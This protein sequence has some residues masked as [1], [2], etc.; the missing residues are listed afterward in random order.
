VNPHTQH[1]PMTNPGQYSYLLDALPQNIDTLHRIVNNIFIHMWKMARVRVPN[2]RKSDYAIR[3]VETILK[4]VMTYDA[5]EIT[6]QRPRSKQFIGDCRHS[7][8]LLCAM[9]RQQ[10]IPARVRHGYCQYISDDGIKFQYHVITEYHDGTRWILEDPDIIRH[11]IPYTDFLFGAQAWELYRAGKINPEQFHLHHDAIGA[12][13]FPIPMLRDIA[14]LA[15]F[16]VTSSDCWSIIH[17]DYVV[18]PADEAMLDD[19]AAMLNQADELWTAV[20]AAYQKYP[21]LKVQQPL[22]AWDWATD[23]MS[24]YDITAEIA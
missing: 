6:I 17:P 13:T 22:V 14:S 2:N 12:W 20:Q 24:E 21:R 11:D 3:S 4:R 9:L 19:A 18:T 8:I 16:E 5:M 15:K 23:K 1:S 7:A 10:G